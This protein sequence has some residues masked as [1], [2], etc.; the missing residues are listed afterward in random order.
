MIPGRAMMTSRP[1]LMPGTTFGSV[2]IL[3]LGFVLISI[4]CVIN[5]GHIDAEDL[6][7]V[8]I[9]KPCSRWGR[10]DFSDM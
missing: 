10:A 3:Q 7:L 4:S 5:K 6:S 1:R 8:G 9:P 2:V